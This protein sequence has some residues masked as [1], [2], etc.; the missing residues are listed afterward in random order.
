M[1]AFVFVFCFFL[2]F[3]SGQNT[4]GGRLLRDVTLHTPFKNMGYFCSEVRMKNV[5]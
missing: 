2:N 5:L 3:L 4:N 1:L